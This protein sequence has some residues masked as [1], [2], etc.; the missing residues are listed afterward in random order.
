MT[1][2]TKGVRYMCEHVHG[3]TFATPDGKWLI[4]VQY[5]TEQEEKYH[6]DEMNPHHIEHYVRVTD[7]IHSVSMESI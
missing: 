1:E 3:P 5:E 7:K 4:H 6:R 2:T